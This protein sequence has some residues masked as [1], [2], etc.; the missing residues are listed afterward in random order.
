[1]PSGII[2]EQ[3]HL[4]YLMF[5]RVVKLSVNQRVQGRDTAQCIFRDLLMCLRTGDSTEQD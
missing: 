2:A 3:G 1:M 5:D 4:A